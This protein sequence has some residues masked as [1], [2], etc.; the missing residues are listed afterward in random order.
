VED[1]VARFEGAE[2]LVVVSPVWNLG[3]PA[4]LK[5]YLDRVFLPGV[6]FGLKDGGWSAAR[7]LRRIVSVHTFGAKRWQ[8]LLIGD[9]PRMMARRLRAGWSRRAGAIASSASTT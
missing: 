8:A 6:T 4:I 2:G 7:W 5:G 1:H 3:Y 9:P